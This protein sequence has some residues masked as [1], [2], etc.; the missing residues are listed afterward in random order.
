MKKH[1]SITQIKMFLRCP[2]QYYFRYIK[3]IKMPPNSAMTM[4]RCIHATIE[5]LYRRQ[6]NGERG[7]SADMLKDHFTSTWGRESR[8]TDFTKDES[9][10]ELKDEGVKLI[11]LYSKNIAPTVKPREVEK[12]FNLEFENVAYTLK[13]VIDLIEENG[14]IVDHKCSKRSPIQTEVDRDIQ[15]SA[16]ALAYCSLYGKLPQGLRFDYLVRN[17]TPKT[18]Q[19]RTERSR[20][21]LDRFLKLIGYVSKSIE[22][23]IFYPNESTMCKGCAYKILCDRW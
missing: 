15:L 11:E 18:V 23:G 10:G 9:P 3:G 19:C 21:A 17:K 7:V 2:L 8:E 13:G 6:I 1:L 5:E 4:G 22:Q 16:Y 20:K 12:A 14:T